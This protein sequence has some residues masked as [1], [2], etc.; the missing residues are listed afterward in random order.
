MANQKWENQNLLTALKATPSE[1]Y[2]KC[3][4]SWIKSWIACTGHIMMA[5]YDGYNK[6][7]Y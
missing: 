2:K 6:D 7:I 4:E 1:A 3:S 5:H